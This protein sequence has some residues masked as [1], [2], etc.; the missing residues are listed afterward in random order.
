MEQH[1]KDVQVDIN[2][3][4]ARLQERIAPVNACHAKINVCIPI[5]DDLWTRVHVHEFVSYLGQEYRLEAEDVPY[6]G[7]R[8]DMSLHPTPQRMAPKSANF[9]SMVSD[10][11]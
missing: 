7:H 10:G 4:T 1:T 9:W 3:M 6:K 8:Y 5:D 11:K 2:E